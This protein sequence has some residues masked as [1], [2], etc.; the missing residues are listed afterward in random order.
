MLIKLIYFKYEESQLIALYW[1]ILTLIIFQS[2]R[3]GR[4]K[5]SGCHLQNHS[6]LCTFLC[7]LEL[8]LSLAELCKVQSG[9]LLS[10]FNLLL[11]GLDLSLKFCSQLRHTVLVLSI[12]SLSKGELLGLAFG[13]LESL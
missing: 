7:L 3:R 4:G 13:S 2:G 5:D 1:Y 12:F 6:K 8:L 9:N 11:V 10:L